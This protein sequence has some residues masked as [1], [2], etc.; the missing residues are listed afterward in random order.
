MKLSNWSLAM[1]NRR[2]SGCSFGAISGDKFPEIGKDI[3][4]AVPEV[5]FK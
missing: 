1:L 4:P 5:W 3:D 2:G